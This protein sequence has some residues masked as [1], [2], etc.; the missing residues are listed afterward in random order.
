MSRYQGIGTRRG[1]DGK[2]LMKTVLYPD[3]P[4]TSEDIWVQTDSGDRLDLL[5]HQYYGNAQYWWVIAQANGL[6]KGTLCIEPG[7]QLRI[8]ANVANIDEQ[9]RKNNANR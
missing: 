2:V 4:R 5:A 8:P 6:G 9:Q 7:T 1:K 3:I